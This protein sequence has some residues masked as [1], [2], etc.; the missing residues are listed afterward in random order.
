MKYIPV[1]LALILLL[2]GCGS[3]A[4]LTKEIPGAWKQEG[5]NSQNGHAFVSTTTIS[6]DGTFSYV[7]L[8]NER[9]LTNTYAGTWKI[10]RG[11]MLMTLTNSSGPNPNIP[12]GVTPLQSRIVRLDDHQL[13]YVEDGR[14]NILSR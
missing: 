1:F 8:W 10:K 2:T 4:K 11:A 12:A 9:P 13:V 7:R 3:D 14:T 5:T 6:P